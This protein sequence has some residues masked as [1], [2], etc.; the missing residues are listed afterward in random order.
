VRRAKKLRDVSRELW[1]RA[2]KDDAAGLAAEIAFR[3]FLE[4]FPFFIFL[5]GLGGILESVLHIHNP[6]NQMLD[7]LE[8]SLPQGA[9]DP[10]RKQLEAVLGSQQSNL[11]GLPL[12]GILWLAAGSG[13]TLLK[14]MNRIYGIEETRPMW[15]RYLV[16]LWLTVLGG[17][18]LVLAVAMM[19]VGQLLGQQAGG[20]DA[21]GWFWSLAGYLRWPILVAILTLEA[22]VVFRVAPNTLPPWRFVTPGAALFV[23]GWLL[24]S[25]LFAVYVDKSGGYAST[26]GVLGGVIV[27]LLWLQLTAY[28]LVLGAEL[29]G[30][31][32]RPSEDTAHA[33][34]PS[35]ETM[36][37]RCTESDGQRQPLVRTIDR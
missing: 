20:D 32:E 27:L 23:G 34:R 29:N 3:S 24:A 8:Q 4:L 6:A 1:R 9:A 26:Y 14:A 7:M 35:A 31:L 10:I 25:G 15:E 12:L 19:T 5:A 18:V 37:T 13:A 21:P 11:L 2:G 16:G 17:A 33:S 30:L 22:G 28:V 36:A